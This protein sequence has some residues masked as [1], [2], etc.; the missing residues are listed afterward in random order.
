MPMNGS[1]EPCQ[2][3]IRHTAVKP[4]P[5]FIIIIIMRVNPLLLDLI[6]FILFLS[7]SLRARLVTDR[8]NSEVGAAKDFSE[9]NQDLR[10]Q[11]L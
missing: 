5:R 8:Q 1:G 6:I 2:P 11:I 9:K 3:P 7:S 10:K 4:S